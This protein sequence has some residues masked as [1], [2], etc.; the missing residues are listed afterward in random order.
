MATKFVGLKE[1]R[2]N[3]AKISSSALRNKDRV[4]VLKKN[5]PLFELRPLHEEDI[6]LMVFARDIEEARRSARKGKT[7]ATDEVREMLGLSAL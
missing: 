2:Q 7:Y 1:L 6:A 5:T 3:M 4:I